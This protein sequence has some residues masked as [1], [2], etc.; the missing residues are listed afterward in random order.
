MLPSNNGK[1]HSMCDRVDA[2]L[3][4]LQEED[5]IVRVPDTETTERI[6]RIVIVPKKNDNTRLCID[7]RAANT[8]IKRILH[9]MPVV[10]DIAHQLNG[11]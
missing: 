7:M 1:F 4:R 9:P 10:H 6:F 11:V 5:I 8:A 2:D 3:S